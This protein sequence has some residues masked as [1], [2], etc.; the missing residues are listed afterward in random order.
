M[1]A[2]RS[3]T[4]PTPGAFGGPPPN[5]VWAPYAQSYYDL[6]GRLCA[7]TFIGR[8]GTPADRVYRPRRVLD[9]GG[10]NQHARQ[11]PYL[12]EAGLA[13]LETVEA[14]LPCFGRVAFAV[15]DVTLALRLQ[16]RHFATSTRPLPLVCRHEGGGALTRTAWR[17][18]AGREVVF[19]AWRLGRGC[20]TRRCRPTACWPWPA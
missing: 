5:G 15:G 17:V 8:D 16:L 1:W 9:R 10:S 11:P 20:C 12:A 13:G 18:L 2:D 7:F 3:V 6:P 14:A 19:W 4:A